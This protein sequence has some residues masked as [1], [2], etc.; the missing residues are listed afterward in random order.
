MGVSEGLCLSKV[1]VRLGDVKYLVG[2]KR[3]ILLNPL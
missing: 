3:A 2:N 1:E